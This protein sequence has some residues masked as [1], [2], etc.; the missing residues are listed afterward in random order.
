MLPVILTFGAL[1]FLVYMAFKISQF[2]EKED[3]E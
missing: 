1:T 3:E 2:R